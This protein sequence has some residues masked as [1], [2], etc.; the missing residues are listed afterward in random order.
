MET[1]K[2]E[3]ELFNLNYHNLIST[4]S[5]H[6]DV[7]ETD[8]KQLLE[9]MY[10]NDISGRDDMITGFWTFEGKN[11]K[12]LITKNTGYRY[13]IGVQEIRK[14]NPK[15]GEMEPKKILRLYKKWRVKNKKETSEILETDSK[16]LDDI[17]GTI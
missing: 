10:R 16:R 12:A 13:L 8:V 14:F 3:K 2:Q 5:E 4:L 11:E 1:E 15:T 9:N 17:L 6:F 7:N